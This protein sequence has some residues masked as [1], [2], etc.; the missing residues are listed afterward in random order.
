MALV[1]QNPSSIV[2]DC[3]LNGVEWILGMQ[4]HDGG[5]GAFDI[6][7]DARWL[8]KIPFSDMDSLID[9]ST[10][11]VTG[12]MLECFGLLLTNRKGACLPQ[13]LQ[14]RLREA[15]KGALKFLLKEQECKGA[16]SGS[17]WG[18]WGNNYNYGTTNVL[19][20]LEFWCYNN[21]KVTRAVTR[22]ISWLRECQNLDGGWGE[23]LLSYVDPSLAGRGES[24]SAQTSWALDSMLRYL[25]ASDPAI[26]RGIQWLIANQTIK[27]EYGEGMSWRTELYA[28]T[29]FP[30]VLYLGYPYYHHLFAVQALS[31]YLRCL[32]H[33]EVPTITPHGIDIS[34]AVVSKLSRRDALFMVLGSRGD[35]DVFLSIAKR[36]PDY[37]IRIA[38]HPTHHDVVQ[39]Q[40]FEFYDA[41]GSPDEFSRIL[42]K[43][44]NVLRSMANGDFAILRQS[45]CSSFQRF[46][47]ASFDYATHTVMPL[48][49]TKEARTL[50]LQPRPFLADI[51]VSGPATTVH[52]HAAEKLRIPL[53]LASSQPAA[54]TR[55]FPPVVTM[56]SPDFPSGK[57]RTT[58]PTSA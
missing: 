28:G 22:A 46:W 31:R 26:I 37:R 32:V 21:V 55:D 27:S 5:W 43:E 1:K 17:W 44:P 34:P 57:W 36:L 45:L 8:H 58:L 25:P 56:T 53:V 3:V 35:I 16:A 24:T 6:N 18:R 23:T 51:I 47:M 41:G 50:A 14:R 33:Q 12:R 15:A 20:G 49:D 11:D 54:P 7:N 13:P 52:I 38:T 10:S 42:G 30:N 4:N 40:G 29:G 19:R 48:I 9:P 2:S 39:D